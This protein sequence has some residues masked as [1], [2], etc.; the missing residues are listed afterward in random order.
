MPNLSIQPSLIK[1]SEGDVAAKIRAIGCYTSQISTF[2]H[3]LQDMDTVTRAAMTVAGSYAE[4]YW[5]IMS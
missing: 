1:L 2:W 4:R 5:S 3:D